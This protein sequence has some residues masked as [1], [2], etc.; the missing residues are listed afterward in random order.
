MVACLE[1]LPRS[2][3]QGGVTLYNPERKEFNFHGKK[4]M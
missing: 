1:G 3:L 4:L 2:S